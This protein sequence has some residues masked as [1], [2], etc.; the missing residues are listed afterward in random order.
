MKKEY[1]IDVVWRSFPLHPETPEEGRLLADLF[2]NQP[3]DMGQMMANLKQKAAEL[4]LPFGD[5]KKTY[6]SRLAQEL[7]LWA[8][9]KGQGEA[10]HMAAFKAYFVDGK[11]LAQTDVLVEL[12]SEV[13][14][15][16]DEA[17]KVLSGRTFKAAVDADW[18]LSR[19]KGV[20]AV[21]TFIVN[22]DRLVGAQPYEML[23]KLMLT[24][25]I[26]KR[27]P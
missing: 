8:E 2:A 7:G 1:R 21:P 4:D 15:D 3:V 22:Q 18:V 16:P 24:N 26:E 14:L 11:N 20:T 25:G 23:E 9:S 13:G 19:E 27:G 5:R 12:A 10:L 17:E 6:N